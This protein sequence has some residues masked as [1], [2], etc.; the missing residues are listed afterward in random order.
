MLRQQG[1]IPVG[2]WG[3]VIYDK[4]FAMCI[5]L[6]SL[7]TKNDLRYTEESCLYLACLYLSSHPPEFSQWAS[8]AYQNPSYD[9]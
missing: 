3:V 9:C 5:E 7:S 2:A 4:N 6:K 8:K 1:E